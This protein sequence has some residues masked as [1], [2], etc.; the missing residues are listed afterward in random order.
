[1]KKPPDKFLSINY[2]L[3]HRIKKY[4]EETSYLMDKGHIN[5]MSMLS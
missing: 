5:K 1:M 2:I 3:I 4:K